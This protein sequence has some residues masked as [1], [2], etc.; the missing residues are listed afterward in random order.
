MAIY[1]LIFFGGLAAGSAVWGFVATRA[2]VSAALLV[3]AVGL[4]IGPLVS[5]R[6][7]LAGNTNLSL[8][9]S[10]HWPSQ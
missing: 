10:L 4:I 9:P 2:G 6:F 5:W 8:T 7:R 1:L 3:A